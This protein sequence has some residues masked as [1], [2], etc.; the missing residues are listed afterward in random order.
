MKIIDKMCRAEADK[1]KKFILTQKGKD[2]VASFKSK[3]VGKPIDEDETHVPLWCIENNY[4]EEVKD[5]EWIICKGY[6]V[7]YNNKNYI[8]SVGNPIVFYDYESALRYMNGCKKKPIYKDKNIYIADAIYEGKI[9]KKCRFYNGKKVFNKDYWYYEGASIGE[10]VEFEIVEDLINCVPPT[11]LKQN[12]IQCGEP[13]DARYD[14]NG[15]IRN[16]YTTFKKITPD[17]Y[18]YCGNCFKGENVEKG[19][20]IDYCWY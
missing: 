14:E 19:I 1:G 16:T 15:N 20:K 12:C 3:V 8:L 7:V 5:E 10:L 18:E 17:I 11:S 2:K 13:Y 6:K 4:V 9:P